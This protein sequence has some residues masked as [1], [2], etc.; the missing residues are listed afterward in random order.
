MAVA[1]FKD[2]WKHQSCVIYSFSIDTPYLHFIL[3][4]HQNFSGRACKNYVE[5]KHRYVRNQRSFNKAREN[6][7]YIQVCFSSNLQSPWNL[8][9]GTFTPNLCKLSTFTF[10]ANEIE[11]NIQRTSRSI[12]KIQLALLNGWVS[13]Y[14]RYY[15]N[16]NL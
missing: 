7:M 10:Q 4:K 5:T 11:L 2:Y 12:N 9:Y 13:T 14:L 6:E 8:I 1:L 3:C 16:V 15:V